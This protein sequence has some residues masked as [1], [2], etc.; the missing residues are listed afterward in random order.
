MGAHDGTTGVLFMVNLSSEVNNL[1]SMFFRVSRANRAP[2][3]DA[4]FAPQLDSIALVT[5]PNNLAEI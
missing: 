5:K 4:F 1:P 2:C 3:W